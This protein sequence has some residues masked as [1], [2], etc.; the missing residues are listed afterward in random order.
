MSR[1]RRLTPQIEEMVRKL[2]DTG[3]PS[4]RWMLSLLLNE[5]DLLRGTV[6]AQ[7]KKKK[8]KKVLM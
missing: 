6:V 4:A 3:S 1:L 7:E 5:I 2:A 8:T